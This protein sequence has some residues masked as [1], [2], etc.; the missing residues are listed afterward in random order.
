MVLL[1]GLNLVSPVRMFTRPYGVP[2]SKYLCRCPKGAP[3]M[4]HMALW[5]SVAIRTACRSY[6][7]DAHAR[8][9]M[10]WIRLLRMRTT[11]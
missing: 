9:A 10:D 8:Y 1:L 11:S 7:L 3:Y 6:P 5:Y 2:S 4:A